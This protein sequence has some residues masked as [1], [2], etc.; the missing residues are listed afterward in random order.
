MHALCRDDLEKSVVLG[1][2]ISLTPDEQQQ[3]W[4]ELKKELHYYLA[5][6]HK[7]KLF[8]GEV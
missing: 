3:K 2:L 8:K 5:V 6:K 4:V 1:L 7:E